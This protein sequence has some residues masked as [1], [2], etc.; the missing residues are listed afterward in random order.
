MPPHCSTQAF[1]TE[2]STPKSRPM[3]TVCCSHI[4]YTKI[5]KRDMN[6]LPFRT[7][8]NTSVV[9]PFVEKALERLE[10]K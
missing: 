4:I 5:L 1:C 2:R 6:D 9:W 7:V 8:M 3:K 10:G